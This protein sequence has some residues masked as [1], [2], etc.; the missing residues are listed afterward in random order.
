M[1]FLF[2]YSPSYSEEDNIGVGEISNKENYFFIRHNDP[3][4]SIFVYKIYKSDNE[5]FYKYLLNYLNKK[6]SARISKKMFFK[7][8]EKRNATLTK[9]DILRLIGGFTDK[10]YLNFPT[11]NIHLQFYILD[12]S[13]LEK[14]L[15]IKKTIKFLK[16]NNYQTITTKNH[17]EDDLKIANKI[18]KKKGITFFTGNRSIQ[19]IDPRVN[20]LRENMIWMEENCQTHQSCLIKPKKISELATSNY[21]KQH[22]IYRH[23]TNSEKY[24][25]EWSLNIYYLPRM[26]SS[27]NCGVASSSVIKERKWNDYRKNKFYVVIG[28]ECG[29]H[30]RGK[31]LAHELGHILGL[32][33]V[34]DKNNLMYS[35]ITGGNTLTDGQSVNSRLY[36]KTYGRR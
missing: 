23:I 25:S 20:K 34:N 31:T 27:K 36:Y 13:N 30:T 22:N 19:F 21:V 11:L 10:K 16:D 26:L 33:H 5:K 35:S 3:R 18:W 1:L 6:Y 7:N 28:H 8:A 9:P 14:K 17:I 24:Y 12:F 32:K 2:W 15:G 4:Q 29:N